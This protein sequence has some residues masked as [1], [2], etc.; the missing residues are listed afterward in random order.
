[1][2]KA[3]IS[4]TT[5]KSTPSQPKP[6]AARASA[7]GDEATPALLAGKIRQSRNIGMTNMPTIR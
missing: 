2:L 3:G 5:V 4:T 7:K 6:L 1:M